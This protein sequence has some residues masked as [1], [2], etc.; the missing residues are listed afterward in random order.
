MKTEIIAIIDRSGSM[1]TMA[2][3]A[4][5]GF[6]AFLS[7]QKKLPGEAKISQLQFDD[8]FDWVS[9]GLDIQQA[10]DLNKDTYVPR[11]STAMNDAIGRALHEQGERI[12]RE[13]WAEKVIVVVL[14]DGAENASKEYT[15]ERVAEMVK[16]AQEHGWSFV[17]LAANIN[18]QQT[19]QNYGVNTQSANNFVRN[20]AASGEGTK[21]AYG[22]VTMSVANLRSGA[23]AGAGLAP[24]NTVLGQP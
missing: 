1:A 10:K 3:E 2:V 16:H 17:F 15:R 22:S 6:N 23:A 5:G 8:R 7:E 21:A 19:A 9:V 12:K 24:D 14:T 4:I 13:G 11:G 20:F 18:A